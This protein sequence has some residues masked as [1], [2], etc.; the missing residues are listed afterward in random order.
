MYVCV[1]ACMYARLNSCIQQL[2]QSFE[3]G[4]PATRAM[5]WQDLLLLM[6]MLESSHNMLMYFQSC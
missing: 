3:D 5:A 6:A 1:H 2:Q 4:A